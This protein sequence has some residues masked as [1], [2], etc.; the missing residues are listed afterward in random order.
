LFIPVNVDTLIAVDDA[1]TIDNRTGI[2][3]YRCFSNLNREI[4]MPKR[5]NAPGT[6]ITIKVTTKPKP[7]RVVSSVPKNMPSKPAGGKR[8]HF[9]GGYI[10]K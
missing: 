6:R 5:F 8:P 4:P 2:L 1:E 3:P 9:G 7:G 10:T